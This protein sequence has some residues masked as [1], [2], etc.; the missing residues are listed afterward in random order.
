MSSDI[1]IHV[2]LDAGR[3][4]QFCSF[5]NF[6]RQRRWFPPLMVS[7][8][9]FTASAAYLFLIRGKSGAFAGLLFGLGLAVPMF[10]F[11]IYLIQIE[12]QIA[13]MRLK[14]KPEIYFLHFQDH[15]VKVSGGPKAASVVDLPW[16]SFFAA[17]RRRD[18]TYLYFN[19]NRAFILPDGQANVSGE[20][21]FIYL[22][23]HLPAGR[24]F[25]VR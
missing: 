12:A 5:D 24:C 16:D 20:D 23:E 7:M 15:G 18:C 19:E 9:L 17:Y 13:Q 11:G 25:E 2:R 3:Y 22:R 4:R 6:R 8:I 10:C 21:L 14:E 1:R